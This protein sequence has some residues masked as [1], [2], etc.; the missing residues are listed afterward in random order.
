VLVCLHFVFEPADGAGDGDLVQVYRTVENGG[1][2]DATLFAQ[3]TNSRRNLASPTWGLGRF[4]GAIGFQSLDRGYWAR[5]QSG[6]RLKH[7]PLPA[8]GGARLNNIDIFPS[9]P[10]PPIRETEQEN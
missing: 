3:S 4:A 6:Q 7:P 9:E 10:R 8:F 2:K 1:W 5:L